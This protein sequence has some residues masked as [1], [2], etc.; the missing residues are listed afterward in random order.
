MNM[1]Q[2]RLFKLP[3][4]KLVRIILR[5][6]SLRA[7]RRAHKEDC[8]VAPLQHHKESIAGGGTYYARYAQRMFNH[9]GH[10]GT[11]KDVHSSADHQRAARGWEESRR[12]VQ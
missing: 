5:G 1:Y 12:N 6:T 11:G 2:R 7:G 4:P 3:W 8:S 9:P 10:S